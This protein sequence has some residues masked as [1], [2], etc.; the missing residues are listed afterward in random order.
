MMNDDDDDDCTGG[1]CAKWEN[2]VRPVLSPPPHL[3]LSPLLLSPLPP[4]P[5][6]RSARRYRGQISKTQLLQC[7]GCGFPKLLFRWSKF[8]DLFS[9]G[10]S[11]RT[12]SEPRANFQNIGTS[13]SWVGFSGLPVFYFWTSPGGLISKTSH[14]NSVAAIP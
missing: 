1:A 12:S 4:F 6:I 9:D 7:Q 5:P 13:K 11:F 14:S 3:P 10:P 8:S 2:R